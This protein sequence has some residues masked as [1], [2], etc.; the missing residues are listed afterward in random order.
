MSEQ[1]Y[2]ETANIKKALRKI[3]LKNKEMEKFKNIFYGII[4]GVIISSVAQLLMLPFSFEGTTIKYG[5]KTLLDISVEGYLAWMIVICVVAIIAIWV[6]KKRSVGIKSEEIL[7]TKYHG[8]HE[9]FHDKLKQFLHNECQYVGLNIN[10]S[11]NKILC[12]EG[13]FDDEEYI[14]TLSFK[15]DLEILQIT[16]IQND[17]RSRGLLDKIMNN[18]GEKN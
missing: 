2:I 5:D 1:E 3:D 10:V 8:N 9:R 4:I 17:Q 7:E 16:L 15:P 13:K 6:L 11:E 12:Y 18:Y 14:L